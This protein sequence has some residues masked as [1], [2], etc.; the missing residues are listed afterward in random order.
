M[1]RTAATAA[2]VAATVMLS[3]CGGGGGGRSLVLYN[4][5]HPQL[6]QTLVHAFERQAGI[7]VQMRS[8]DS[9]V[10]ATQILQE[11]HASPADVVLAENS[12]ELVTLSQH[13]LL[14]PLPASILGKVPRAAESPSGD[15]VGMAL[16]ISS[17]IYDPRRLPRAQLPRSILD[18]AQP[19]W[20]GKVAIAPADSDFPPVVSAV[21]S[22]HGAARTLEWLR[23]LKRNAVV[24]QDEEAVVAAVNRGDVACGIVN[25]YYWYRLQLEVG[26]KG[27][28]STLH[29]FPRPDVGSITNIA[30][31]AVL[32]S[33]KHRQQALRFVQFL[34]GRSG[35]RILAESDDFEYP[36]RADVPANAA[37]PPLAELPHAVL[38]PAAL[39]NGRDAAW[40]IRQSGLV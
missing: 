23:G 26:A 36:A 10:I 29:Y 16:R 6:T 15:W 14:A 3:A 5:Q 35:Q 21:L 31:A 4:G 20:K 33:S 24:H 39:G 40:L 17:L 2:V 34:V 8:G 32:A 18:L 12:P 25:Q 27:M 7:R 1:T 28:H 37:L 9:L 38:S 13:H 22:A 11:G 30:G 19:S